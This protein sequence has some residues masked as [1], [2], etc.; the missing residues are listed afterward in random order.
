[1]KKF[2][3]PAIILIQAIIV[4]WETNGGVGTMTL[5]LILTIAGA[6]IFAFLAGIFSPTS[7]AKRLQVCL[8]VLLSFGVLGGL[9]GD[10]KVSQ[11][12]TATLKTCAYCG[13][14]FSGLGY[15]HIGTACEQES[16]NGWEGNHCSMRC[17]NED[18]NNNG[19]NSK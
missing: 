7:F 4:L 11:G 2:I 8:V 14:S 12:H 6:A 15:Y 13:K 3:L 19:I 5:L 10:P 16:G 18:W 9:L 17:C 1:M